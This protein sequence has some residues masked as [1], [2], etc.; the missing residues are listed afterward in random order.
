MFDTVHKEAETCN[1]NPI[2]GVET[3]EL[4]TQGHPQLFSKFVVSLGYLRLPL[5]RNKTRVVPVALGVYS[6]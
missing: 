5:K 2:W 4:K 6:K 3:R 1:P